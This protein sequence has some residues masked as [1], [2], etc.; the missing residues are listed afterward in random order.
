MWR[1]ISEGDEKIKSL[2][3]Y[4]PNLKECTDNTVSERKKRD[5][6]YTRVQR[7]D[8]K[9][10][11]G[12]EKL[13]LGFRKRTKPGRDSDTHLEVTGEGL[14]PEV[15]EGRQPKRQGCSVVPKAWAG[16]QREGL[17]KQGPEKKPCLRL[18]KYSWALS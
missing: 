11:D 2:D 18:W 3:K 7:Q 9:T 14:G 10:T 16:S 12:N 17:R 5:V 15:G 8:Y 6:S 13:T 1:I 4:I